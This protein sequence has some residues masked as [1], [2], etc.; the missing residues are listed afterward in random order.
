[1][2]DNEIARLWEGVNEL[3]ENQQMQL[4]YLNQINTNI[5]KIEATMCERCTVRGARI[6]ALESDVRG[7]KR[8]LWIFSGGAAVVAWVASKLGFFGGQ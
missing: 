6:S 7:I 5:T 3:R 8:Q 2:G 1:M 4:A